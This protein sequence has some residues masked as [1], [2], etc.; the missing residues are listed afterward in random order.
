VLE[1]ARVVV[2]AEEERARERAVAQPPEA[3]DNAVG[4]PFLL[5]L[6]HRSPPG[7]VRELAVLGDHAVDAAALQALEPPRRNRPLLRE[8]RDVNRRPRSSEELP[9]A[10]PALL[11]GSA[12]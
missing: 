11:E 5:H 7:L 8:R 6:Q 9:E 4:R 10:P 12:P 3:G 2:E 1:R